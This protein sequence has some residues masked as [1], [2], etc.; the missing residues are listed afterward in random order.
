MAHMETMTRI[1]RAPLRTSGR[2]LAACYLLHGGLPVLKRSFLSNWLRIYRANKTA[3]HHRE[4]DGMHIR[5]TSVHPHMKLGRQAL[6]KGGRIQ[7]GLFEL[8]WADSGVGV[9]VG[10]LGYSHG[11][12]LILSLRARSGFKREKC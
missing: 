9:S 11:H 7:I 1:L 5:H 6:C 3:L 8:N 2:K 4:R 10:G 12:L